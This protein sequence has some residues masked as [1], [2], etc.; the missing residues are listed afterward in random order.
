MMCP[1]CGKE[2]KNTNVKCE[3]CSTQLI[4]INEYNSPNKVEL[5]P[6]KQA[7]YLLF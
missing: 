7:A 4:D 6:K 5:S 1:N 2:N 3:F